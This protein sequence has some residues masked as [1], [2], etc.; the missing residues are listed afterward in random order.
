M[1]IIWRLEMSYIAAAKYV[2]RPNSEKKANNICRQSFEKFKYICEHG[3]P[4]DAQTLSHG[5]YC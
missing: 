3:C 4:F 1:K 5:M 2:K